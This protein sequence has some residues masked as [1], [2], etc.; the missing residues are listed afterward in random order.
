[1]QKLIT[2]SSVNNKILVSISDNSHSN[3][4]L[5]RHSY[6]DDAYLVWT[7]KGFCTPDDENPALGVVGDIVDSNAL[8]NTLYAYRYIDFQAENPK[9]EDYVYSNWVRNGGDGAIG[10]TFGNY[11]VP[12]GQ[13]GNIVTPDDLRFTY[14]WGTDFKATNGQSYTDEQI[15]YFID[16]ATAELE[17]QLD[18]TIKK[19]KIRYNATERKLAKGA[20]Y[21][22]DESVYDFKFSRISRY[23]LI[24]TRRKPIAKLHKL[25]LLSRFTGTKDLTRTTIVDKT[26]GVLKLMERPLRPSE[27]SSGI[28]TAIGIYGNQTLQSQLFYAI[29]YDAGFETSDD[30]PQDLRE[31][32][33]KQAAISLLNIVGDGLMSGFSSSSLSMDGLSESFSSTQS[34]TSAYF[35]AR[36]AVYKDDID[37]YIK[38]NKNKFSNMVIGAI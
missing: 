18:I 21:D 34:A 31:V 17:R 4:R 12:T 1:M 36:I 24:Q 32:I 10:Y 16:S 6:D 27:T 8:S 14:L 22:I 9:D 2:A 11:K 7:A 29:D 23:G 20:D 5:E 19:K 37:K 25:E 38:Q 3:Y 13:W 15:Q 33:A 35:G 30:V 28:Q 26:K